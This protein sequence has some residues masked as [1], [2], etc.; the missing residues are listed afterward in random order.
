VLP[1]PIGSCRRQVR[2]RQLTH[3]RSLALA[4][5]CARFRLKVSRPTFC[6][7]HKPAH[8]RPSR[9]RVLEVVHR[10]ETLLLS[11][12]QGEESLR[13]LALRWKVSA[14]SGPFRVLRLKEDRAPRG[15]ERAML[16][17]QVGRSR[18]CNISNQMHCMVELRWGCHQRAAVL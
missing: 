18:R 4:H 16:R 12:E 10:R 5:S 17:R 1:W 6:P 13:F 9:L 15:S 3:L 2:R 8:L 7:H 11:R 14:L